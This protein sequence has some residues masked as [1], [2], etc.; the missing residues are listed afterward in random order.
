MTAKGRAQSFAGLLTDEQISHLAQS[1]ALIAPFEPALLS[2]CSYDLRVGKTVRSRNRGR[3]FNIEATEYHIESGECV[4]FESLESVDFRTTPLFGWIVNK[5]SV[6]AKG[7]VHPITKVDPG[8]TG[9]LAIT[10]FNLG[11]V[12]EPIRL[13]QPLVSLVVSAPRTS[14]TRIYGVSQRPSFIEGSLDIASIVNEPAEPLDDAALAR[15]YGRPLARVYERLA[16]VEDA[17][18][19]GLI[20]EGRG[21]ADWWREFGIRVLLVILGAALAA[22]VAYYKIYYGGDSAP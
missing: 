5:H 1:A 13:G 6:L 22:A 18:E 9:P 15:M 19:A 7:L 2:G 4:T 12:A 3:T 16:K 14:P 17:I 20:K 8:F 10:I 11:S 21:R